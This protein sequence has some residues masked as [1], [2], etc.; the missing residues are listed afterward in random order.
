M[1]KSNIANIGVFSNFQ[2]SFATQINSVS[3]QL[4][5]VNETLESIATITA[6][7]SAIDRQKDLYE[8]E[9]QKRLAEAGARG[10]QEDLLETKIQSALSEPVKRIGNKISLSILGKNISGKILK[11]TNN[12]KNPKY[13]NNL[14]K[15]EK[16]FRIYNIF[17][18][19]EKK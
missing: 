15:I 5:K 3:L 13:S 19:F 8:Q 9:K 17:P 6:S 2:Q 10:G 7:E 16:S 1:G 11:S 12:T 4:N 18:G 14:R